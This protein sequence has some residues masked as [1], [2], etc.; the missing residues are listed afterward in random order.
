MN[1]TFYLQDG[2]EVGT[3]G[4]LA[5]T[6]E[7]DV[8]SDRI[9]SAEGG[10]HVGQPHQPIAY[11][12][13]DVTGRYDASQQTSFALYLDA[14][15][16][17]ANGTHARV[18]YDFDGD[19]IDDRI[20]T[21]HYFPTNDLPNWERYDQSWGLINVSGDFADM[22]GGSVRLE[23]WNGIGSAEVAIQTGGTEFASSLTIPFVDV[24]TGNTTPDPDPDPDPDPNPD[25]TPTEPVITIDDAVVTERTGKVRKA[26]F[27]VRLSEPSDEKVRVEFTTADGTAIAGEDY[28]ARVGK[29]TF[30]PGQTEKKIRIAV[31][32]DDVQEVDEQFVVRLFSPQGATV[33]DAEAIGTIRDND[34]PPATVSVDDVTVVEGTGQKQFAEFTVRLSAP[35][36]QSVRI[37]YTTRSDTAVSGEDFVA[38]EDRAI[39]FKPGET[40]KTIRV[41][42]KADR[43]AEPT[44][45]FL[46]EL[47]AA[48]R[49][50][51]LE[52]SL[53][54]ATILDDDTV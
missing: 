29:I 38:R 10:Q 33:A 44:E 23:L 9:A 49:N 21:Y 31:Q 35:V 24:T 47:L 34:T 18:S 41:R 14:G 26:T 11:V 22:D 8:G 1:G 39:T 36:E 15:S 52:R 6:A 7:T 2:A 17:V 28:D 40:V 5:G 45:T 12:V 20:E 46:L 50:V 16:N 3:A 53:A 42:I 19:G 32:D 27:V 54:L 4:E 25:P 51:D 43:V 13:S 37:T 48:N 30:K